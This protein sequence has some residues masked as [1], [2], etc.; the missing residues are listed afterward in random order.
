MTQEERNGY[1]GKH[2]SA[3]VEQIQEVK[4]KLENSISNTIFAERTIEMEQ[5]T[6]LDVDAFLHTDHKKMARQNE[7]EKFYQRLASKLTFKGDNCFKVTTNHFGI[8]RLKDP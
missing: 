6:G 8:N 4:A 5:G 1:V 2:V 3:K 7:L